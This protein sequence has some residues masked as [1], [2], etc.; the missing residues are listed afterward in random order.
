MSF[1]IDLKGSIIGKGFYQDVLL[2]PL[3]Q[4][5]WFFARLVAIV[6]LISTLVFWKWFIGV[7]RQ[8]A[9]FLD[10]NFEKIEFVNGGIINMPA[11]RIAHDSDYLR[12]II[13][14]SCVTENSINLA[15]ELVGDGQTVLI[16]GPHSAYLNHK[17]KIYPFP[18]PQNFTASVN[19][20]R[21]LR[22]LPLIGLVA[23]L[24]FAIFFFMN[25]IIASGLLIILIAAVIK[26]KFGASGLP[27]GSGARAGLYL[28]S[29]QLLASLILVVLGLK[30]PWL[31]LWCFIY[32]LVYVGLFMNLQYSSATV[33]SSNRNVG[34]QV[35][36]PEWGHK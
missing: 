17:S 10:D 15:P 30:V 24:V 32:Y 36:N 34:S 20:T 35:E 11:E 19:P 25:N 1:L 13:D 16:I 22:Q 28:I 23:F 4:G 2:R 31:F 33:R 18:Y 9:E 8:V 7:F 3:R 6:A 26:F 14:A 29:H 5:F 21:L 27:F 12:L